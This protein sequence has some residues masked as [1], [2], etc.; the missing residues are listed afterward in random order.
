MTYMKTIL[1]AAL[2]AFPIFF[3]AA[4]PT[5]VDAALVP[6]GGTGQDPCTLCHLVVGISEIITYIRDVMV[7]IALA[8]IT[9]MGILYI[10]SAGNPDLMGTAKK[11]IIAS[12]V[13][14]VIVLFA[15]LIVN[16]V[17]F[18]VFGAKSDLGV[19]VTFQGASGFQFTCSTQ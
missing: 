18:T 8:V 17:M 6:C 16:T 19:G 12:L 3:L 4:S 5:P 11:G 13:G 14:V 1:F 9:A 7:F 15:W 2:L 10:V